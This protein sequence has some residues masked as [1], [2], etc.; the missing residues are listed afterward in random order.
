MC[1]WIFSKEERIEE[2]GC[3][4]DDKG[5][6]VNIPASEQLIKLGVQLLEDRTHIC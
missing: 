6:G 3:Y 2:I 5:G 4:A 1:V